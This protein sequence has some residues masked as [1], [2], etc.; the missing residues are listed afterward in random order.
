MVAGLGDELQLTQLRIIVSLQLWPD[1]IEASQP[2]R[3]RPRI[4]RAADG[5]AKTVCGYAL[6]ENQGYVTVCRT[7]EGRVA[8]ALPVRH[9]R[10]VGHYL[11]S[12]GVGVDSARARFRSVL[13]LVGGTPARV[14]ELRS[15]IWGRVR[16]QRTR[17]CSRFESVL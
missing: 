3:C 13:E 12:A 1:L 15:P 5:T 2:A 10:G 14:E 7:A 16:R 4:M 8:R 11:A 9:R 6:V 17:P